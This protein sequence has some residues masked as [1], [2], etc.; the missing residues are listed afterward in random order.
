MNPGGVE[1][2]N[3]VVV[4]QLGDGLV[5][6]RGRKSDAAALQAFYAEIL[7]EP[8][9]PPGPEN[10]VGI[11]TCDL[12]TRP[13]PATGPRNLTIV[14]ET[15]TGRIVSALCLIPQTWAYDGVEF[16]VGQVELVATDSAYR[17][18]GLIRE[19]MQFVHRRSKRNGHLVQVIEGIPYFY[20]QF[21]YEMCLPLLG[22]RGGPASS[23]PG[24]GPQRSGAGPGAG[25]RL[26]AAGEAD[27]PF[28]REVYDRGRARSLVSSV[29]EDDV[30]RYQLAGHSPG[31]ATGLEWRIIEDA[32]ARR[33]G[34]LAY[35]PRFQEGAFNVVQLELAEEES[36]PALT[37]AILE[38]VREA[39]ERCAEQSGEPFSTFRFMLGTEHPAYRATSAAMPISRPPYAWYVRVPDLPAFVRC[40]APVLERRLAASEVAGYTG[41]LVLSFY[42]D[43]LRLVFEEGRVVRVGRRSRRSRDAAAA[44]F[45]DLAF[46]QLLFGR[47][48]LAELEDWYADCAVRNDEARL[49]IEALFPRR[50]S[51]TYSVG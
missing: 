42:L 18:R 51:N 9:D 23:L 44:R 34:Y 43:G 14:E 16:G 31:S 10:P 7:R 30:W 29:W 26:R 35:P 13:H 45:P 50:P 32:G 21:G 38:Y 11:W 2:G 41:G 4:K 33:C 6:R 37:P 20:R 36:W 48:S 8:G 39:G 49:L 5:I 24:P 47:R 25:Y 46:L 15:S 12:F 19:Q 27:I 3:D 28:L 1:G 17:N 40:I 22:F